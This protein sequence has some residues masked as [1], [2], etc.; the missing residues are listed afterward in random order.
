[1][2]SNLV[3]GN[4]DEWIVMGQTKEHHACAE[5]LIVMGQ[6]KTRHACADTGAVEI[7]KVAGSLAVPAKLQNSV[8]LL[9]RSVVEA[10]HV[11][12]L[13]IPQ[14]DSELRNIIML[15]WPTRF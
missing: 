3:M 1:M 2:Q 8:V 6:R 10:N 5:E 7:S 4:A 13:P 14:E 9:C 15:C 11:L 12:Q